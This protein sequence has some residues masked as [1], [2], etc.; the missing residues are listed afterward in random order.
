MSDILDR[1]GSWHAWGFWRRR[2][3]CVYMCEHWSKSVMARCRW[4]PRLSATLLSSETQ[5]WWKQENVSMQQKPQRGLR[6]KQEEDE[7]SCSLAPNSS[8]QSGPCVCRGL[9]QVHVRRERVLERFL[10][11]V[12]SVIYMH[13]CINKNNPKAM[14]SAHKNIMNCLLLFL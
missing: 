13:V 9:S 14:Q 4:G 10:P 7:Q 11:V 2:G 6:D 5:S 8:Q 1:K 12:K 3:V